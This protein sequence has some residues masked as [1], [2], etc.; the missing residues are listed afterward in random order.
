[1]ASKPVDEGRSFD[2]KAI[3]IL[4]EAYAGVVVELGLRAPAERERAAKYII[5]L[6]RRHTDLD[7]S[8]LR[9]GAASSMLNECQMS[10]LA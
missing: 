2:P 7:A 10:N 9:D 3:A 8:R 6:A 4:L 1:M 5:R